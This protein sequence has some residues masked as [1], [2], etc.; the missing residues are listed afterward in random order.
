MSPEDYFARY[1][2]KTP[3]A[4]RLVYVAGSMRN[5]AIQQVS[6]TLRTAGF[7]VFDDW[8]ASGPETDDYWQK[9]EQERGRTYK[10]ALRGY[11]AGNVFQFDKR[12]L[13]A[14]TDFVLVLPAGK[15]AHMELGYMSGKKRT[16]VL[17]SEGEPERW[18]VMYQFADDVFFSVEELLAH[19]K[20]GA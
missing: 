4:K 18:D 1:G 5:P 8:H 7:D 14:S 20:G 16:Y 11:A 13:D 2:K 9:Y 10:E 17:F 12:H 15:S 19:M 6:K 3:P